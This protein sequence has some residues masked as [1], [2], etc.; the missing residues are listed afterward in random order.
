MQLELRRKIFSSNSTIGDLFVD[1]NF[2]CY[3]LGDIVHDGPKV[4]GRTAIP[5]GQYEIIINDSAR[6]KRRMPLLLRVPGFEGVRIHSGNT[7]ARHERVHFGWK[8]T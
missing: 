6:F 3:T 7:A 4:P 2:E 5:E 1:G 8:V